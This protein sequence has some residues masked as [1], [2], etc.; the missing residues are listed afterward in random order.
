ML[1]RKDFWEDYEWLSLSCSRIKKNIS[2]W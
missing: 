2:V 1:E